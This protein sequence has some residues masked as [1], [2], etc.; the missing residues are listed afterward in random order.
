M[1]LEGRLHWKD[2][3]GMLFLCLTGDKFTETIK[4]YHEGFC[5]GHYSWKV[6]AHK[7]L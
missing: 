3:A 2:P 5:G 1:I 7:I 6:T 4:D